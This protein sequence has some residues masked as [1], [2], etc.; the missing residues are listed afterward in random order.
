MRGVR[1]QRPVRARMRLLLLAALDEFGRLLLTPARRD[2][3]IVRRLGRAIQLRPQLGDLRPKRGDLRPLPLDRLRLRQGDANQS[4][5]VKRIKRR[6]TI[7]PHRESE[8]DSRVNSA[9]RP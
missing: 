8:D 6:R 3:R 1:M 7:H 2:A 4:F 9:K 5:P